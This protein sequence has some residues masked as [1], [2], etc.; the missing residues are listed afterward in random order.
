M[1]AA[2]DALLEVVGNLAR[3]HREHEKFY[4]EAPLHDAIVLQRASRTLKALSERWSVARP[5]AE[6]L[7]SP[8][9]GAPDLNDDRA[10]ETLGVLFM[11]GESEPSE[12]QRLK[13]DLRALAEGHRAIGE[14]LGAA[15]DRAWDIA[16]A[17]LAYPELADLL[18]E[19]HRIIAND[20]QTASLARIIARSVERALDILECMELTPEAIRTDLA[21]D[22]LAARRLLSAA[23]MLDHAADLAAYSATLTHDNDR[24]WRIFHERVHELVAEPANRP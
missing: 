13:A 9:A 20:W 3:Y 18:A 5:V 7:P 15:M 8:F 2:P 19:R 21:G 12:I 1:T 24:R 22:R 10:I 11:E 6:P 14:W 17:L 4:A 23:E 16:G